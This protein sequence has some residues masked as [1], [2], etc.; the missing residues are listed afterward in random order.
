LKTHLQ[1]GPLLSAI[2]A[3]RKQIRPGR[4]LLVGISGIDASGKSFVAAR[5]AELLGKMGCKNALIEADDWLN[6]PNIR[7]QEQNPAEH[8]YHHGLRLDDMF[9][10]LVLPLRDHRSIKL[11]MDQVHETAAEC[12]RCRQEYDDIEVILVEGIFIFKPAYREHFDL[13]AWIECSFE[14]AR[15]RAVARAQEGL[16]EA[17]TVA[18]YERI[19]FAAQK[20]HFARDNPRAAADLII[21]N[22]WVPPQPKVSVLAFQ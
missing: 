5:A 4:A 21:S 3:R 20:L 11:E 19:Y 18:A 13:L 12:R 10:Q 8:F 16:P 7:F 6:L 22:R 15:K 2:V 14:T 1:L 9:A 17:E